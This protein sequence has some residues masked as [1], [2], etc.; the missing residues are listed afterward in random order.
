MVLMILSLNC[1]HGQFRLVSNG[2]P[3][4]TIVNDSTYTASINFHS[5]LTGNSYLPININETYKVF[6]AREQVYR[7]D[8][9]LNSTFS[10]A[11]LRIVQTEG[12]TGFPLGQIL[13]YDAQGRSTVPSVPVGSTASTATLQSAIISWNA[14]NLGEGI[15]VDAADNYFEFLYPKN[16][17]S[18]SGLSPME[19][20]SDTVYVKIRQASGSANASFLTEYVPSEDASFSIRKQYEHPVSPGSDFAEALLAYDNRLYVLATNTDYSYVMERDANG[21]L[22]YIDSISLRIGQGHLLGDTLYTLSDNDNL[23]RYDMA[24]GASLIDT[25]FSSDYPDSEDFNFRISNGEYLISVNTSDY[26]IYHDSSGVFIRDTIITKSL[27]DYFYP[28]LK[29]S[30][31]IYLNNPTF[32]IS[33]VHIVDGVPI[34]YDVNEPDDYGRFYDFATIND[35]SDSYILSYYNTDYSE[36]SVAL[37]YYDEDSDSYLSKKLPIPNEELVVVEGNSTKLIDN[38]IFAQMTLSTIGSGQGVW[39]NIDSTDSSLVTRIENAKHNGFIQFDRNYGFKAIDDSDLTD[40][41]A[42]ELNT[43]FLP[44]NISSS[45]GVWFTDNRTTK[46]GLQY[47]GFGGSNFTGIGA[48]YSNLEYNSLAPK[49]ITISG[50]EHDNVTVEADTTDLVINNLNS[51]MVNGTDMLATSSV[52]SQDL[53]D[54]YDELRNLACDTILDISS[55][56][57]TILLPPGRNFVYTVITVNIY[58]CDITPSTDVASLL[59]VSLDGNNFSPAISLIKDGYAA[60]EYGIQMTEGFKLVNFS[61]KGLLFEKLIEVHEG[62]W[63][64]EIITVTPTGNLNSTDAQAAFEEHQTDIDNIN[65]TLDEP[66]TLVVRLP[67]FEFDGTST[68][69]DLY[70]KYLTGVTDDISNRLLGALSISTADTFSV[71]L[72]FRLNDRDQVNNTDNTYLPT[73]LSSETYFTLPAGTNH[74]RFN[75]FGPFISHQPAIAKG[76]LIEFQLLNGNGDPG[77]SSISGEDPNGIYITL[78]LLN[79]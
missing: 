27:F 1:L 79:Y 60:L 8:S 16:P 68:I 71:D 2:I 57:G 66:D 75:S 69:P 50:L 35:S 64:S 43:I 63:E 15:T 26:R 77:I 41:I 48:D 33:T 32:D 7:V 38:K 29:K 45:E 52:T 73:A 24:N 56:N 14:K 25:I 53:Q 21:D 17:T 31:F 54:Q 10:S 12:L 39:N 55:I 76:R 40:R 22:Q 49:G 9:V 61:Y 44:R 36:I 28:F 62:D 46:R 19:S 23:I 65:S 6:T 20:M 18:F 58:D 34:F 4:W 5:D 30:P 3:S 42:P 37:V 72:H 13:V 78:Y 47:G 67:A 74:R 59:T 11:Q 51:F 70:E